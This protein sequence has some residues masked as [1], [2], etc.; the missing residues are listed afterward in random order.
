MRYHVDII[1]ASHSILNVDTIEC[2]E[3]FVVSTKQNS[4]HVSLLM[5]PKLE[6]E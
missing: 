3:N 5:R 4:I 2:R 1:Q 6:N